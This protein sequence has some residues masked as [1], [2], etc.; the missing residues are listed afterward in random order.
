MTTSRWSEIWSKVALKIS[1]MSTVMHSR[2]LQETNR[3]HEE[4]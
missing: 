4:P 2:L 3:P 1:I